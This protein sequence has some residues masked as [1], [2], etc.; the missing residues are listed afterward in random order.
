MNSVM[1]KLRPSAGP[2]LPR[3]HPWFQT[4]APKATTVQAV[5]ATLARTAST[6]G[7]QTGRSVAKPTTWVPPGPGMAGSH[8][9]GV[10]VD[11]SAEDCQI[12]PA[13]TAIATTP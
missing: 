6:T 5:T 3:S 1:V 8:H 12:W 2:R 13:N 7:F 4:A 10:A 11:R 9:H